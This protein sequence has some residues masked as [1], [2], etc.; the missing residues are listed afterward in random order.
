MQR[1]SLQVTLAAAL[2]LVCSWAWAKPVDNYPSEVAWTWL[3][4]LYDVIKAEK[5]P[6]P[7]A[8][9]IYGITAVALS[10]SIVAGA[11][12]N[13]SLVR[14]V[15]GLTSVSQPEKKPRDHRATV[16]NAVPDDTNRS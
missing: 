15:N 3:E 4:A 13:P 14:Q 1:R 10:E 2:L 11:K 9:R 8:S 7:Q 16:T 6:P 5:T 12:E